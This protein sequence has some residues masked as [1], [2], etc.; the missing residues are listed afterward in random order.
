MAAAFT[1]SSD[2]VLTEVQVQTFTNGGTD[3]NF[4]A[5]LYSDSSDS[6]GTQIAELGSDITAPAF[7]GGPNVIS[8]AAIDLSSGVQYWLVLAPFDTNSGV[9]WETGGLTNVPMATST[10]GTFG[11]TFSD[12]AQFEIEGTLSA[13]PEPSSMLMLGTLIAIV[14][15][16]LRKRN[17]K[18]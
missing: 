3:N 13:V 16:K 14:S 15:L 2:Y 5:F 6:P 4:D 1:P 10:N 11:G 7:G 12:A 18:A 17:V 8:P 9:S